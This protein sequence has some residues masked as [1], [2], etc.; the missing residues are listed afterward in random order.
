MSCIS[1]PSQPCRIKKRDTCLHGLGGWRQAHADKSPLFYVT[2]KATDTLFLVDTGAACSVAPSTIAKPD[3]PD[4]LSWTKNVLPTIDGGH[5]VT[6][7]SL[8]TQLDLGFSKLSHSRFIFLI[9][10]TMEFWER[11]FSLITNSVLILL[12]VV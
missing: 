3:T 10:W 8:A 6:S 2:D 5:L 12:L 1:S 4:S 7:G 11:I 9:S